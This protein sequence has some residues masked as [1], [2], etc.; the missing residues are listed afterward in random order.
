MPRDG[1][2]TRTRLLDTAEQLVIDNGFAATSVDQ[3][4]AASGSSKG[5]F[6][7]HFASKVDLAR[8]LVDR[9]VAGDL[10]QLQAGLDAV[11][12]VADPRVRALAFVA[13]FEAGADEL[14]AE[15][16]SCLYL[17]VLAERQLAD[18]GTHE[19][20]RRAVLGWREEVSGLL[21]AAYDACPT[22]PAIDPDALAD[23]LF[24]TFEGAFTLCRSL[25]SPEPMRQQLRV[26]RELLASLLGQPHD[27]GVRHTG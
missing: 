25:D 9:Y 10:G 3:V 5:A 19:E 18:S 14:M 8:A 21:S 26:F 20:V 7:H 23:H 4:I 15:Q 1:S 12:D 17:A 16:S 22:R 11:A 13:H 27:A 2:A 6:F 24:A